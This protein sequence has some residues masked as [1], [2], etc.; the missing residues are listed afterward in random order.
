MNSFLIIHMKGEK[1]KILNN[2]EL[3]IWNKYQHTTTEIVKGKCS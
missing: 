1:S 3:N 2:V